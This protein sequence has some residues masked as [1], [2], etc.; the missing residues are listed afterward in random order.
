MVK[1]TKHSE[2]AMF[3]PE[4]REE[5]NATRSP[6][7]QSVA[8]RCPAVVRHGERQGDPCS[9]GAGA[10]TTHPGVGYCSKHGGNTQAGKKAAARAY[11]R[12]LVIDR[13]ERFGGDK[14]APEIQN[15][16]AEGALLE[17]LRRST[18]MVRWLEDRIA[19]WDLDPAEDA[20]ELGL[21]PLSVETSKGAPTMTDAA[22]WLLL[23]R[24]ERKHAA[25]V[26]K[27]CIDANISRR[28]VNLAE[29]Q[30]G[31]ISAIVRV[32]LEAL[33]LSP[34]QAAMVPNVV[35]AAIQRAN[36]AYQA[37]LRSTDGLELV[38]KLPSNPTPYNITTAR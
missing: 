7:N 29:T 30:A 14:S 24:E 10:N 26:A 11:G 12:Q 32:V 22:A 37:K 33:Q 23:Y 27:M 6:S 2:T 18:A 16:T 19:E 8:A 36:Q 9:R 4:Q 13:K 34:D 17:E 20:P 35:P 31:A 21:P 1:I 25:M 15:I 38:N 3:T 5:F 28:L